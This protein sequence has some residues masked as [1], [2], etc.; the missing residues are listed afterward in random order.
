MKKCFIF[1]LEGT[2][3]DNHKRVNLA[4]IG[5][6]ERYAELLDQDAMRDEVV[7][8]YR[9]L[10]ALGFHCAIST[11]LSAKYLGKAVLWLKNKAGITPDQLLMRP[12]GNLSPSPVLKLGHLNLLRKQYTVVA[13][14]EDRDKNIEMYKRE[15]VSCLMPVQRHNY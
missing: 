6:W 9:S 5:D 3:T 14:F 12:E 10:Q 13:V 1:D 8:I 2:L 11:G 15:G 7:I 4:Q